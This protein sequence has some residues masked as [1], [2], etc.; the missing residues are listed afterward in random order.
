MRVLFADDQIPSSIDSENKICKQEL[1]KELSAKI[2]DFDSAYQAE[3][4]WFIELIRYLSV[5]M[6]INIDDGE[7][8]L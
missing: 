8:F 4:D 6:G 2:P 5:D 7:V 3:F 1:R